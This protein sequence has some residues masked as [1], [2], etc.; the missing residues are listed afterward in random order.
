MENQE[1]GPNETGGQGGMGQ[2]EK[3]LGQIAYDA[4]CKA[5]GGI[6]VRGDKLPDFEDQSNHIATAWE[7]SGNAVAIAAVNAIQIGIKELSTSIANGWE[8]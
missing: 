7:C 3:T 5:V 8:N 4:Y 6:S 1:T 2:T